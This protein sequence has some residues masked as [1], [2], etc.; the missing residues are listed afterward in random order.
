MPGF[1]SRRGSWRVGG[2]QRG[3]LL[4]AFGP[5]PIVSTLSNILYGKLSLNS[6]NRLSKLSINR[7]KA[8]RSRVLRSGHPT[9]YLA[10]LW[11]TGTCGTSCNLGR[12]VGLSYWYSWPVS[13]SQCVGALRCGIQMIPPTVGSA[14][15]ES[16]DFNSANE[17]RVSHTAAAHVDSVGTSLTK[18]QFWA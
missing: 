18:E 17:R 16:W 10:Q 3:P 12:S 2:P 13:A 8:L 7:R 1:Q 5:P 15:G 14:A 11:M 4:L 9:T 6:R